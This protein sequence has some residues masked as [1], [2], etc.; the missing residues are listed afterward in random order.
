MGP[1]PFMGIVTGGAGN[2]ADGNPLTGFIVE[3][4]KII[5]CA[6][7][8]AIQI[9][10]Q[11]VFRVRCNCRDFIFGGT[12]LGVA[13]SAQIFHNAAAP[14]QGLSPEFGLIA[15]VMR[16]MTGAAGA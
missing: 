8:V 15:G 13:G 9:D 2:I 5:V 4:G 12:L 11:L 7:R 10:D 3:K 16:Q 6:R 14:G 1:T